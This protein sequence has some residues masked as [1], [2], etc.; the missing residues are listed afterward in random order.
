M[1]RYH[2]EIKNGT[3]RE[4]LYYPLDP[5]RQIYD[6]EL[7]DSLGSTATFN[8]SIPPQNPAYLHIEPLSTKVYV[9]DGDDVIYD[10]RVSNDKKDILNT[11]TVETVGSM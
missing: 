2:V 6:D 1:H 4:V 11:G 5:D 7:N 3:T 9:Y 8:F 10:G